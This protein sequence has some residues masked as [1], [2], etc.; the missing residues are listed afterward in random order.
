MDYQEAIVRIKEHQ[1]VHHMKEQ[2]R[3]QWITEALSLAIEA[4]EW[5]AKHDGYRAQFEGLP[6]EFYTPSAEEFIVVRFN[7]DR[8]RLDLVRS[9]TEHIRDVLPN[10]GVVILPD[11]MS[12]QKMRTRELLQLRAQIDSLLE[13]ASR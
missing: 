7:P 2:P 13:V 4:I 9:I 8:D 1:R 6:I 11:D 3:C 10:S 12:L 5:K